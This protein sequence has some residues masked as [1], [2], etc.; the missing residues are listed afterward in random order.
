MK[1]RFYGDTLQLI[2]YEITVIYDSGDEANISPD[3][4]TA[5]S[6][7]EKE[8]ILALYPNATVVE[9]DNSGYEWLDGAVF[10]QEQLQN[11]DLAKA[12]A[13]GEGAYTEML[14]MPSQEE[15]NAM[16]MLEIAKLKA[17]VKNG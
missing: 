2:K 13:M 14:N 1:Y 16:L 8:A 17:G 9:V 10:T 6:D 7:E 12:I 4:F 5:V 11:G 3:I 15:I